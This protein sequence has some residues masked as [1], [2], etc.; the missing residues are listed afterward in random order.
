MASFRTTIIVRLMTLWNL[1][2]NFF[3]TTADRIINMYDYIKDYIQGNNDVWLFIPNH[4]LPI[5][6]SNVYN[7]V[8]A[9]WVYSAF[10]N[11]LALNMIKPND[12]CMNCKFSW[13]SCKIKITDSITNKISEY[14][15]DEFLESFKII[16]KDSIV[17]SLYI[18]FMTWCAH[19]KYWFKADDTVEFEIIDNMG[20]TQV[21]NID[22]NNYI[23]RIKHNK[24][25]VIVDPLSDTE[26]NDLK[27]EENKQT[28]NG[29]FYIDNSENTEKIE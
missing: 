22:E 3:N 27:P 18:I 5:S 4:S 26:Q 24:I 21:L 2:C 6:L 16:T 23:L 14:Y 11:I 9:N 29:I 19:K 10:D 28:Q 25:Y 20:E 1:L 13:L 15:I 12:T 17:P 7:L 8:E